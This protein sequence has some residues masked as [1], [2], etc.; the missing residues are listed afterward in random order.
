[1]GAVTCGGQLRIA[2]TRHLTIVP[3]L[4]YDYVRT[5]FRP[6]DDAPFAALADQLEAEGVVIVNGDIRDRAQVGSAVEGQSLVFNLSGQS[7]AVRSMDEH[8]DGWGYPDGLRGADIPLAVAGAAIAMW[9]T[10]TTLNIF[11]MIGL[12]LLMGI[13]KKNSIIL[14]DYA[15]QARERGANAVRPH[16]RNARRRVGVIG[17]DRSLAPRQR[18]GALPRLPGTSRKPCRYRRTGG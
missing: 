17:D 15:N 18:N 1:M 10:G 3:D 2:V 14:V 5:W 13:V 7:G 6:L 12:L 4:R 11:S 9:V 16:L 8:W